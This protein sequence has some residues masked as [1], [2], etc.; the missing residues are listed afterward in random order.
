MN[1][2]WI[3]RKKTDHIFV[4]DVGVGGDHPISIQSMTNTNTADVQATVNQIEQLQAAG[5]DIVRVS[6]PDNEC[7][8]AFKKI[9]GSVSIPLVADI[10][11]DYK[12]ALLVADSAD[13]L[14]I[15]PGNIGKEEKVKEII[16]ASIDN[17]IPIRIGVNAGS[18]EKDLQKKYGEPNSDA[19]VES[20]LRHVDI[21][22][23]HDF[24]NF[25]LSLKASNIQM[26]V[27]SYRKISELLDQPCLLYT[28]PSPRD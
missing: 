19:L 9:K 26:T 24:S 2:S 4:G 20:A 21:L 22:D 17:N 13:C 10:H 8:K 5:A 15:N 27:E 7:A 18:L 3:K 14:R 12:I 11:F 1:N 25:K 28:S 16:Q 6:V 23:K